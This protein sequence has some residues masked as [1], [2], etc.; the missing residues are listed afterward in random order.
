MCFCTAVHLDIVSGNGL[1]PAKLDGPSQP[2]YL[3]RPSPWRRQKRKYLW[4]HVTSCFFPCT[5]CVHGFRLC[6][7]LLRGLA[8]DRPPAETKHSRLAGRKKIEIRRKKS[9]YNLCRDAIGLHCWLAAI[10]RSKTEPLR[11]SASTR[12]AHFHVVAVLDV[13]SQSLSIYLRE[14]RLSWGFEMHAQK[15]RNEPWIWI[16]DTTWSCGSFRLNTLL[17]FYYRNV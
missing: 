10:F 6:Q 8:T 5:A 1:G 16:Y 15:I 2:R 14:K 3:S 4:R 13:V 7:D 9:C 17:D 11:S 12:C